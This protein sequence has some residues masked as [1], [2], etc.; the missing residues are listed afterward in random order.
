MKIDQYRAPQIDATKP[1]AF[2]VDLDGTLAII[3]QR[4][5]YDGHLCGQDV[6]NE[7]LYRVLVS[8]WANYYR[9]VL[10]SGRQEKTREATETW[11][12]ARNVRYSALYLREDKDNRPDAD[13]KEDIYRERILPEFNV[14]AVFDDRPKV[15]RRWREIGLNV[16][17][18]GDG[19]EF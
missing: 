5:P 15:I 14:I 10:V 19:A 8:L 12:K 13:V 18:C 11:L 4:S 9:I 1:N 17:D 7:P 2:M 16:F 6:L 3:N